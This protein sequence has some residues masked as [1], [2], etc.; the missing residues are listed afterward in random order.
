MNPQALNAEIGALPP[1]WCNENIVTSS[2]MEAVSFVTPVL[3][4]FFI[5]TVAE[6]M[7]QQQD[8]TLAQRCQEFIQEESNHSRAHKK[9]NNV[10][11]A[12]LGKSPRGLALVSA[13][14]DGAR[15]HLSM[16]KR[17]GL[18]AALEHLAAV[19][20]KLYVHQQDSLMFASAYAEALFDMHAREELGHRS[21][22]FDLWQTNETS[23]RFNRFLT[24]S[25]VLL[26]GAAYVGIAVPWILYQK[27]GKRFAKTVI[28][29]GSFVIKNL[30][31]T[32]A[33]TPMVELFS[34]TRGDFHPA[35][36]IDDSKVNR[37]Q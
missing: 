28:L 5:R 19:M 3:E 30:V 2:V 26:A 33:Q 21:V 27:T 20:S 14:L 34:F 6:G 16:S 23:G 7:S 24:I 18:A 4:G 25:M 9:F 35:L 15:R 11:L 32:L 17:L 8:A 12:Y 36:L 22:V 1:N 31:S 13:L 10:L 29:L 37:A